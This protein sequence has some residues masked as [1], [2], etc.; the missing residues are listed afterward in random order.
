MRLSKRVVF[1]PYKLALRHRSGLASHW[2]TSHSDLCTAVRYGYFVT[3]H[4]PNPDPK[5]LGW[6]ASGEPFDFYKESQEQF[7]AGVWR[8]RRELAEAGRLQGQDAKKQKKAASRFTKLD[9]Y[10]EVLDLKLTTPALVIE[11]V[12][13]DGNEAMRAF[14]ARNQ[15]KLEELL[16]DAEEWNNAREVAKKEKQSEWDLVMQLATHKC[17][18]T[19]GLCQWW[20]A[21][22]DFL[23]RNQATINRGEL[24]AC[25]ANVM[26]HGPGKV[27]RV[28]LIAGVS[29]GAKSTMFQPL[30]SLFG[31]KN[32]LHRPAEKAT[33]ALANA[34]KKGKRFIFWDEY[35]PVEYAA[36]G[37]VPVGTFLSL[38]GG[39]ALEAQVSQ[40]FQNGNGELEW[41]K[42]AAMTAKLEGLWD[43]IAQ[44]PG[45]VPVT[46][47]DIKHMQNRVFQ[48][49]A[50]EK[51]AEG[52]EVTVPPCAE[53][54]CRW[55]VAESN[56]FA[57]RVV[58][59][60]LRRLAGRALPPLPGQ[61]AEAQQ[62]EA[63]EADSNSTF[64]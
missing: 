28:P 11:H 14:A 64:L 24:A 5:P 62:A 37:T 35:R 38:F 46:K 21:A 4:K 44:L 26:R 63:D 10:A 19:G 30:M 52:A 13:K 31:F 27:A 17:D 7:D 53:S 32:V 41:K 48:F 22:D 61:E 36:R 15:R 23:I 47:E 1:L 3:N 29:N 39:T 51:V 59:R 58:E 57:F 12:Q 18:C 56:S 49:N 9:F 50:L 34:V 16:A 20:Q 40:S 8:K 2:S 6:V 45:L 33:M 42:G 43:P 60:P 25:V 54:F 55:L